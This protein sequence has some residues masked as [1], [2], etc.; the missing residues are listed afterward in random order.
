MHYG[1][2]KSRNDFQDEDVGFVNGCIDPGDDYVLDLLAELDLDA[3]PE[4]SDVGCEHCDGE[5]C[6]ECNDTG[7]KRAR[8]RGFVGE[9][10]DTAAEILAAVRENHTAQA[11]GRYARNPRDPSSTATV[12]VRTDVMP[13][14]FVDVQVPGVEWV[15]FEKQ[16]AIVE[17]L[18][19]A[20]GALTAKEIAAEV[21]A[22]KRHVQRTLKRLVEEDLVQAFDGGPNGAVLYAESGLP[23]AGVVDLGSGEEVATAPVRDSYTWSVAVRDPDAVPLRE[24][25]GQSGESSRTGGEWDWR[26][27][28]E[29]GG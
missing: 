15:Y 1:A 29:G 7:K 10:S 14:G 11:A 8:G 4:R 17:Q 22:S 20:T 9:D 21:D 13:T 2:E 26:G 24:S 27:A 28:S 23:H 6:H 16:A 18:R 12:F 19:D 25:A 3:R 5:G